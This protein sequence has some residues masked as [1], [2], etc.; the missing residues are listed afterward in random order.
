YIP[1]TIFNNKT[2]DYLNCTNCDVIY[3]NPYPNDEDYL[4]MYPSEYQGEILVN[5]TSK[6]DKIFHQLKSY[7]SDIES[8]LDYGCG[9]A[10]LLVNSKKFFSKVVGSEYNPVFVKELKLQIPEFTFFDLQE[11][12]NTTDKYDVIV[13]NNVLE[14]LT[15]PNEVLQ[16][17]KNRLTDNGFLLCLGPIENNFT[18]AL[19]FRKKIYQ[20]RN[21]LSKKANHFPYHI[22]FTNLKNQK[23][24]FT[25]NNFDIVDCKTEEDAWPFPEKIDFSSI[26][27]FFYSI[28][29]STSIKLSKLI[30]KNA[31]NTFIIIARK[32]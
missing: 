18:I 3:I 16:N 7:N 20:L 17:L 13:M 26:K 32:K 5:E 2:F 23:E 21:L 9:N 6:Y 29:A 8:I 11:F 28:I 14:H 30:N 10:E 27:N 12:D 15:N 22:T 25:A 19:M 31:G 1:S 4:E 24:I